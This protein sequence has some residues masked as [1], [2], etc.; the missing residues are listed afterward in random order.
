MRE[1]EL[2]SLMDMIFGTSE[3]EEILN[4]EEMVLKPVRVLS[5]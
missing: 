5:R 1:G 3:E 4:E 2:M